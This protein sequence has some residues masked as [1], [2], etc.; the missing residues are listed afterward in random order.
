MQYTYEVQIYIVE[1]QIVEG[2]G[3]GGV[4]EKRRVRERAGGEERGTG[5]EGKVEG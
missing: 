5:E 1:L 3:G 4:G 2:L